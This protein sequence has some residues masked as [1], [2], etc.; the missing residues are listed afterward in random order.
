MG[1]KTFFCI[2]FHFFGKARP[3]SRPA[4]KDAGFVACRRPCVAPAIFL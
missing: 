3:V 2:L 1:F 4:K